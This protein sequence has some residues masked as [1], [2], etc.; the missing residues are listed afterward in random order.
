MG[1]FVPLIKIEK[2]LMTIYFGFILI[3]RRVLT[4]EI[5]YFRKVTW[6]YDIILKMTNEHLNL[7]FFINLYVVMF[8]RNA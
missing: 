2:H 4:T 6:I 5:F 8:V 1:A 3:V 7:L